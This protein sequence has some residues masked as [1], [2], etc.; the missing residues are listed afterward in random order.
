MCGSGR[1]EGSLV[2]PTQ[3]LATV[4]NGHHVIALSPKHGGQKFK[5]QVIVF[6]DQNLGGR[7]HAGKPIM[8]AE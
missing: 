1:V 8:E 6:G 3:G 5:G 2:E 7:R 4:G